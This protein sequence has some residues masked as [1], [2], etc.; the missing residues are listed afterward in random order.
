[1]TAERSLLV[2]G[3]A[4]MD[5]V[6]NVARHPEPGET[7]FGDW[8]TTIP[9]GKGLNQA[10]AAA[11]MG[12]RVSFVGA[13]GRDPYGD[14]LIELLGTAG[15]DTTAVLRSEL[16]TGTAHITVD[17]R[18]RNSIVVVSGAN[19]ELTPA[20]LAQLRPEPDGW[21]LTQLEVP[22]PTVV[23]A[24]AWCRRH[25]VRSMLTPAPVT[26]LSEEV[27]AQVDLLVPNEI[28]AAQLAGAA[29]PEE[30]A[31]WLS[32][33]CGD[34]VVTLGADGSL[35]ARAGR[36]VH[37]EPS[38]RVSP[39]DTT[40]AGDTFV[41]VLATRLA[42]GAELPEAMRWASAAAAI[43]VTRAGASSSMPARGEVVALL[44]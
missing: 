26:A 14:R 19:T 29:S 18:G 28:E 12:A 38:R 35:W 30:A 33:R 23:A 44:S 1:M 3:S 40:A 37:H 4:N 10:V 20:A 2:L 31:R 34:V 15:I 11:R 39:V 9:G 13:V 36:I 42:E 5:L 24:L 6:V 21:L 27:L 22:L 32:R 8:F 43:G 41:G 17:G 25:R 7:V 16:S